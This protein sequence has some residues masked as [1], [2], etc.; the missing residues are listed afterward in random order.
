MS[1]Q[2]DDTSKTRI[3]SAHKDDKIY[4]WAKTPITLIYKTPK[5][6]KE[7]ESDFVVLITENDGEYG[8]DQL[9]IYP[10]DE[11]EAPLSQE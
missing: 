7:M 8:I 9:I 10:R 5:T 4:Y 1:A 2:L 6:T 11:A 3:I